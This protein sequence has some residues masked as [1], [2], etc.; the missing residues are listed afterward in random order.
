MGCGTWGVAHGGVA[1][2]GWGNPQEALGRVAYKHVYRGFTWEP[3]K[4]L[5]N[6]CA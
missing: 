4:G 3:S 1:R 5:Y 2:G 6:K